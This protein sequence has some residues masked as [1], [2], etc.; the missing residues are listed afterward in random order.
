MASLYLHIPF[1]EKKCIYCDFYSI[2]S[3]SSIDAFLRALETEITSYAEYGKRETFETIF[4]GGGTPSLLSPETIGRLLDL[5]HRTYTVT[6][7]A[8][9]TL[10][11]NPGTVDSAKLAGYKSAGINRL[12]FGVQSFHQKDLGFLSRIH[13][14]Q[15]ARDAVAWAKE[16]GFKNVNIDLI[17]ALPGQ[18]HDEWKD[19]L[20]QAMALGTQHISAY[21]LIVEDGTPLARMVHSKQVSPAPTET[22]AEMYEMTMEYL[23][24]HGFVHYEVSNYAL[25]GC[26]SQHNSNYWNHT[27]YLGFGP[28][29][30]SF[31]QNRRWWNIANIQTY[32]NKLNERILPLAGEETLT[33]EQLLEEEIMLNARCGKIDLG[34]MADK[35]GIEIEHSG[36]LDFVRAMESEGLVTF[37]TATLYTLTPKGFLV[38]EE[39]SERLIR[40]LAA[41][42]AH[43]A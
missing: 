25:P 4:F 20:D 14:V 43:A 22:E 1:C 39:I 42:T 19:N 37:E 5:L 11:T 36:T 17:Y 34:S 8:E 40:N 16:A 28:S 33:A 32:N 23:A 9:I 41:A 24:S 12:S 15:E 18:T 30:H 21:N 3:L 13:T 31:W 26:E 27:N 38:C 10:E 2:E 6:D 35:H 29:A 7:T